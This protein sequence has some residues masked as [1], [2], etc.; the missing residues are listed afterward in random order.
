MIRDAKWP[1][2][3]F[4]TFEKHVPEGEARNLMVHFRD[5]VDRGRVQCNMDDLWPP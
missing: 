3:V 4:T 1:R 2:R 5:G